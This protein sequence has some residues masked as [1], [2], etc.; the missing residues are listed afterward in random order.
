MPSNVSLRVS[1]VDPS[2]A[3]LQWR[4]LGEDL[5]Q[6]DVLV[7]SDGRIVVASFAEGF[8][9]GRKWRSCIDVLGNE[10]LAWPSH[11]MKLPAPPY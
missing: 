8:R 7:W 10:V 3:S 6:E 1:S 11:W 4:P 2:E 5:P 9:D